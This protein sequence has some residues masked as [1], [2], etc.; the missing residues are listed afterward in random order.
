M[1][2]PR[3]W[4]GSPVLTGETVK[5]RLLTDADSPAIAS[6][7]DWDTYHLFTMQPKSLEEA[8]IKDFLQRLIAREA[9]VPFA[10]ALRDS[11]EVVGSSSFLDIRPDHR[12][13]EI[14]F[15]WYSP[16]HRRTKVNPESKLLLMTYAFETLKCVRVQLKTDGRNL[17]SQAAISKLGAKYEGTYR[18]SIIMPNGFIRETVMYSVLDS[19]WPDVK[20]GLEK[21]IGK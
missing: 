3:E 2:A 10:V 1:P 4:I 17:R 19:E 20:L 15:T 5:L 9:T 14:G 18:N 7:A 16:A 21:R 12:G 6:F 13:V 11:G 8:D